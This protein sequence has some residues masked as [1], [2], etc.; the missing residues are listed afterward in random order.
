MQCGYWKDLLELLDRLCVGEEEWTARVELANVARFQKGKNHENRKL[1]KKDRLKEWR[2][3]VRAPNTKEGRDAM[4]AERAAANAGKFLYPILT[5]TPDLKH[6]ICSMVD[7]HLIWAD[8]VY[9]ACIGEEIGLCSKFWCAC[10]E[11]V[12]AQAD[13]DRQKRHEEQRAAIERALQVYRDDSVYRA[14]HTAV[15]V[16]FA[17]QLRRDLADLQAGKS[18]SSLAVKW[19][20][21]PKGTTTLPWFLQ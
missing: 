5:E 3:S 6:A 17:D 2:S 11:T 4:K 10:A 13:E 1:A 19:A 12:K 16:L 9:T 15:A 8:C 14:L 20:P 21:T 18:V 7:D